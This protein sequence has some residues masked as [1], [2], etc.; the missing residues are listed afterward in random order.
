MTVFLDLRAG[1]KEELW[2][3]LLQNDTEQVAIVF[4]AV[5]SK[6]NATVFSARDAYLATAA[7]FEIHSEFHVE[8][9][10]EARAR[11]IKT[12]WDT[13][14]SP[15]EFHSHPGDYRGAKFSPS[16]M[17]GFSDYVPHCRWRL[18]G[19]PYLAVVV[20]PAGMDALAWT[21][22]GGKPVGLD[23]IRPAGGAAIRPTNQTIESLKPEVPEHG[24]GAF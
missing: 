2:A 19:R 22:T 18:R 24:S 13:G 11:I 1:L 7:D 16:D 12:A 21:D 14:T 4:A 9:T 23:A 3:H 10:D 20:T 17:Y 6:D 15:V 8:L 5:E